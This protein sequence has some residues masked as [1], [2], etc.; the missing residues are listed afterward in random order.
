MRRSLALWVMILSVI[1]ARAVPVKRIP[2][3][4]PAALGDEA[5]GRVTWVYSG[6]H[7]KLDVAGKKLVVLFLG[8]WCPSFDMNKV[9]FAA[10]RDFLN[11]HIKG[12]NV[13]VVFENGPRADKLGR[14]KGYVYLDDELINETLIEKGL[15]FVHP[16]DNFSRR[17]DFLKAQKGAASSKG[18]IWS[19]IPAP[20]EDEEV[21][22]MNRFI[23]YVKPEG[24]RLV[25]QLHFIGAVQTP[26]RCLQAVFNLKG[27]WKKV[28]RADVKSDEKDMTFS[29][30]LPEDADRG[31]GKSR[32][33]R[34][35][36]N[37][38]R[39]YE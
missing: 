9:Y 24:S 27:G 29:I 12:K 7:F 5:T 20:A 10:G 32:F 26:V 8:S 6:G 25:G 31:P 34:L 17:E 2:K 18:G 3:V 22:A 35:V 19:D 28:V 36:I 11:Q 1:A 21:V 30:P 33:F 13:R 16:K 14:V 39:L 4:D 15:S 38:R 23:G 37:H